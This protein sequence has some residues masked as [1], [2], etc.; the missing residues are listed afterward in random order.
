MPTS[1]GSC[2]KRCDGLRE[3]ESWYQDVRI[4]DSGLRYWRFVIRLRGP[5]RNRCSQDFKTT[6]CGGSICCALC[7]TWLD[8]TQHTSISAV[9]IDVVRGGNRIFNHPNSLPPRSDY[10]GSKSTSVQLAMLHVK[11][12]P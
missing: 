1:R 10:L 9:G 6:A 12:A 4:S 7:S 8:D 5:E 11:S 3:F 2:R